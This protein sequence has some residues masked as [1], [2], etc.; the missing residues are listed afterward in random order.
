MSGTLIPRG[1]HCASKAEFSALLRHWYDA[2]DEKTIGDLGQVAGV[3]TWITVRA[4]GHDI[5]VHADTKRDG[6]RRYLELAS[7]HGPELPWR[8]QPSSKG[9]IDKVCVEP[10]GSPTKGLYIYTAGVLKEP[11]VV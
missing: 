7:Q 4:G 5:V 11:V 8:V 2:T 3:T 6:V 10:D 1:Q 9:K